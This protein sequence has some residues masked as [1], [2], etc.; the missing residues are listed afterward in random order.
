M[1]SLA[2]E[3]LSLEYIKNYFFDHPST[4]IQSDFDVCI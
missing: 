4:H 2:A 3:D 1:V